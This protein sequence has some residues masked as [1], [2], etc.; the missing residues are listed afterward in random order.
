MSNSPRYAQF[1]FRC[2]DLGSQLVSNKLRDCA[3]AILRLMPA[4]WHTIDKLK[5]VCAEHVKSGEGPLAA[6]LENM[7]FG[8]SPS[9]VLYNLE[10]GNWIAGQELSGKLGSNSLSPNDIEWHC[11]APL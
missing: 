7:F 5:T 4:D 3:R 8:I 1:L 10:V 11:R 2:A 6:K 9:Q